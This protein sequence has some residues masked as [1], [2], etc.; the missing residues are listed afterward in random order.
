MTAAQAAHLR[1]IATLPVRTHV[2]EP[3]KEPNTSH[4]NNT[5]AVIIAGAFYESI[6]EASRQL[7]CSREKIRNGLKEG[8]VRYA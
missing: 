3:D 4:A 8:A 1:L 2:C 7:G 6:T 5:R